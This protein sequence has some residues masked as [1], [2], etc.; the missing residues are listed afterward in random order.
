MFVHY[1]FLQCWHAIDDQC[2]DG[3]I[4]NLCIWYFKN[5]KR[6]HVLVYVNLQQQAVLFQWLFFHQFLG[7]DEL[8][9]NAWH[10]WTVIQQLGG[11]NDL[12]RACLVTSDIGHSICVHNIVYEQQ[13]GGVYR[14]VLDRQLLCLAPDQRPNNTGMRATLPANSCHPVP[15]YQP[16]NHRSIANGVGDDHLPFR[17]IYGTFDPILHSVSV[18]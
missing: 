16:N 14:L 18:F 6:M 17:D 5:L 7:K 4:D 9:W 2:S 15:W 8:K 3:F 11:S 10:D 13:L 12:R 1:P